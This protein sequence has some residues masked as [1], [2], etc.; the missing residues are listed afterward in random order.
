VKSLIINF[1]AF[2]ILV[3]SL[4]WL[5][6]GDFEAVINNHEIHEVTAENDHLTANNITDDHHCQASAH[7]M[8]AILIGC[9]ISSSQ[10]VNQLSL[11]TTDNYLSTFLQHLIRP[12]ISIS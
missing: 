4:S 7:L 6:D 1:L 2:V 11:D 5:I 8:P 3:N 9:T 10:S 12:P